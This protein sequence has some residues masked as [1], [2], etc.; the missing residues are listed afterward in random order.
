MKRADTPP[1]ENAQIVREGTH[2]LKIQ[3]PWIPFKYGQKVLALNPTTN[4]YEVGR[5][6]ALDYN[7]PIL[8]PDGDTIYPTFEANA[9]FLPRMMIDFNVS[10]GFRG[11]PYVSVRRNFIFPC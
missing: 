5:M 6:A 9:E 4:Q 8:L 11:L 2:L 7:S 1:S 10:E 3:A